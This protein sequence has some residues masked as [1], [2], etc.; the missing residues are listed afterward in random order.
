MKKRAEALEAYAALLE[1]KLEQCRR[2]HGGL[3]DDIGPSYLQ[4]RPGSGSLEDYDIES[5]SDGDDDIAQQLCM[6]TENLAVDFCFL[7]TAT[8]FWKYSSSAL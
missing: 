1:S 4:S 8:F 2:E 6:P 3:K 5:D 7:H